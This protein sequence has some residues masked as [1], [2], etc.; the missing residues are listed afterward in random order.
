MDSSF[1]EIKRSVAEHLTWLEVDSQA[2]ERNLERIKMLTLPSAEVLAVIKANAYGHGLLEVAKVL[3]RKVAY[4]GVASIE[5]AIR[6]RQFE[7][8]TPILLFGVH[9]KAQVE[10]AIQSEVAFSVSSL[11]QAE[12]IEAVSREQQKPAVIHIK[13]D[14]GMGRLGIPLR[15]AREVIQKIHALSHLKLEGIYT[16]FPSAEEE[17][18]SFTESQMKGFQV[19][20]AGLG[21]RG[22]SFA[23]RHAAN[24]AGVLNHR[25]AH[26]NLVR[27]GLS[28]YGI[29]PDASLRSKVEL[30]PVLQWRARVILVKSIRAGDSVGYGRTF[31]AKE[32]MQ[33]AVLPVGYS[34]GYPV[35][36]SGKSR[37]LI[38]GKSYPV[39]G[40]VSMDYIVAGIGQDAVEAGDRATLIGKDG[41]EEIRAEEL[42]SLAGTIPY[43]IITRISPQIP[44]LLM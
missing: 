26:L 5:E 20:L 4:F 14:T 16:H 17:S 13:V 23:Y 15:Q 39:L 9:F 7:V 43:E 30:R 34:Q 10:Q 8:T 33:I 37:V 27:P 18:P 36:L 24:S 11:E 29:Y 28:L 6:L 21:E 38:R 41:E 32:K 42:A 25:D 31:V 12:L 22:V 35:G 44:R 19:L 40:R 1:V 3:E 2:L